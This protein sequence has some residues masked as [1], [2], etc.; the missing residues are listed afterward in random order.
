VSGVLPAKPQQRAVKAGR[1]FATA[2]A[3]PKRT[4]IRKPDI[5]LERSPSRCR[6]RAPSPA[7]LPA[8]AVGTARTDTSRR[9]CSF[10][11]A[12]WDLRR[13]GATLRRPTSRF[14]VAHGFVDGSELAIWTT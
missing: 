11:I 5:Y 6:E 13:G 4:S 1:P 12:A 7:G 3:R 10:P 14:F 8:G 9:E 2:T